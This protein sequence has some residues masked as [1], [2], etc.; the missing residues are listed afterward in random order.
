M[1]LV[2]HLISCR[3]ATRR[4]LDQTGATIRLWY[5][6]LVPVS[7]RRLWCSTLGSVVVQPSPRD[8]SH[9]EQHVGTKNNTKRALDSATAMLSKMKR[10]TVHASLHRREG[11]CKKLSSLTNGLRNSKWKNNTPLSVLYR[12]KSKLSSLGNWKGLIM[13]SRN[14]LTFKIMP[15]TTNFH[16][17][18][19]KR[20]VCV[21]VQCFTGRMLH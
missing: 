14:I 7:N 12:A 19:T 1:G 15:L 13:T 21:R 18:H 5:L 3:N 4:A 2:S 17:G 11:N 9:A 20:C 16:R 10:S 6:A 8:V